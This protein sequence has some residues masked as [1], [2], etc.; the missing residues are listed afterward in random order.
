MR[1]LIIPLLLLLIVLSC[2]SKH[3]NEQQY[4][5][6]GQMSVFDTVSGKYLVSAK[7]QKLILT[8]EAF[9]EAISNSDYRTLKN[10]SFDS[11]VC[12]NCVLGKGHPVM[13]S[14]TFYTRYAPDLF[15]SMSSL[16]FDS[17][18]VQCS[19]TLDSSYFY[20]YPVL[21]TL[22]DKVQPKLAIIFIQ[23]PLSHGRN[24]HTSGM[25][26]FIETSSGYKFF[27]YST[28]P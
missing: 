16:I 26:G 12:D 21:T 8:W 14:D 4:P 25:L 17:S 27:G 19:Y 5:S 7:D 3:S 6:K 22:S 10:L 18:K 1:L 13:A 11:I 23:H 24:E 2:T 9:R 20:A 15:T 28:I